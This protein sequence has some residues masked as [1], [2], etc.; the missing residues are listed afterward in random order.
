MLPPS[1][2]ERIFT[3]KMNRRHNC[4]QNAPPFFT[5]SA[6]LPR[7]LLKRQKSLR[8]DERNYLQSSEKWKK[9]DCEGEQLSD[10]S[11]S[12]GKIHSRFRR[13]KFRIRGKITGF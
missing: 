12:G 7:P 2:K 5:A 8:E 13:M 3:L 10:N 6:N 11:Y 1:F 9:S 4:T